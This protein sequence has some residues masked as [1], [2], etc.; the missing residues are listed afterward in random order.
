MFAMEMAKIGASILAREV[1]LGPENPSSTWLVENHADAGLFGTLA[2]V[3]AERAYATPASGRGSI[4]QHTHHLL[5]ACR[6]VN[7]MAAGQAPNEDWESSWVVPMGD[8]TAWS[9][10]QFELK[11]EFA[12]VLANLEPM[13]LDSGESY[14]ACFGFIAHSA[15]HLGAIRQLAIAP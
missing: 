7:A 4:A 14:A 5:F 6:M 9:Q 13:P 10:M 12:R 8:E 2:G 11:E 15:Y 3:S 1:Y